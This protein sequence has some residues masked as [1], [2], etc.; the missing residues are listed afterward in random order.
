[1]GADAAPY[2]RIFNPVAQG[3]KFDPDGAYVRRWVP[4]LAGLDD[5]SI[6][7]PWEASPLALEAAGI[8]LGVDYPAPLVEHAAARARALDALAALP[9]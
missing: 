3:Q 8:R 2:F 1:C 4:E 5:A 6:H 9:K 7:A